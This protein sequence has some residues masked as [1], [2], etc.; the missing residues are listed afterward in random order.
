MTDAH[1][2]RRP[3][4]ARGALTEAKIFDL[5]NR[6]AIRDVVL[7]PQRLDQLELLAKTRNPRRYGNLE[8]TIVVF[9]P[10]TDRQD[11]ASATGEIQRCPLMRDHQWAVDRQHDNGGTDADAAGDRGGIGQDHHWIEAGAFVDSV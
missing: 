5:I 10:D 8:L 11:R 9:A 2:H 3:R 1:P 7:R 6:T 4:F